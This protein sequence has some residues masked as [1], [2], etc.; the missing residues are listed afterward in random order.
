MSDGRLPVRPTL[1]DVMVGLARVEEQQS[2]MSKQLVT[3]AADVEK[4]KERR[5]PM[6]TIASLVGVGVL[7]APMFV[8]WH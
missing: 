8:P 1:T 2:A 6:R 3:V 4:L 5:W 7:L